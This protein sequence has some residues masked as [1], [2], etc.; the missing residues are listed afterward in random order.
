[1]M[2]ESSVKPRK[3][4]R[5]ALAALIATIIVLPI[6][7]IWLVLPAVRERSLRQALDQSAEPAFWWPPSWK[8]EVRILKKLRQPVSLQFVDTP[9]TDVTSF[10]H[11]FVG[12]PIDL[13]RLQ[14]QQDW[15]RKG[16]PK[17]SLSLRQT[18]LATTLK[19]MLDENEAK[20]RIVRGKLVI[21]PREPGE[22]PLPELA[23]RG[24]DTP[25]QRSVVEKLD[26]IVAFKFNSTPFNDVIVYFQDSCS[27]NIVL[28]RKGL[29]ARGLGAD[30]EVTG[31]ADA[32]TLRDALMSILE[33]FHAKILVYD[34]VL[35]VTAD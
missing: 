11:E 17:I 19:L 18:S 13:T 8:E 27:A 29:E 23:V 2:P 30:T 10:L 5:M 33:P 35:I 3:F 6:V 25:A 22:A 12:V 24:E 31:Q 9:L 1:M 21:T 34:G 4:H 20:C 14:E 28:D 16:E 26:S 7:T 15:K 32:V